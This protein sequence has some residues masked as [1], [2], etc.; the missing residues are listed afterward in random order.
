MARLT[1]AQR[2]KLPRSAFAVPSKAPGP[3]SFPIPDKKHAIAAERE[4]HNAAPGN[5]ARILAKAKRKLGKKKSKKGS[6][7]LG[8]TMAHLNVS[9]VFSKNRMVRDSDS[10]YA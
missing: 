9:K 5:R 2:R 1:M 4:V 7:R 6:G 10:D 8:K 3:G